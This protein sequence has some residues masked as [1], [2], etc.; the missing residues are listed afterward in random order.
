M[1]PQKRTDF[2]MATLAA[3][4]LATGACAS[5]QTVGGHAV[6]DFP[7]VGA[8]STVKLLSAGSGPKQM[9]RWMPKQGETGKLQVTL[10]MVTKTLA[11]GQ[12]FPDMS[13]PMTMVLAMTYRS[14]DGDR[15]VVDFRYESMK[16]SLPD[17]PGNVAETLAK[18]FEKIKGTMTLNT[19][20]VMQKYEMELPKGGLLAQPGM[21]RT[22][23]QMEDQMGKMSAPFPTEAV[24]VGAKWDVMQSVSIMGI[25][26]RSLTRFEL[27]SRNE[28]GGELAFYLEQMGEKGRIELPGMTAVK[29]F[30][31]KAQTKGKGGMSFRWDRPLLMGSDL[32]A[33]SG[34]ELVMEV[35]GETVDMTMSIDMN[36]GTKPKD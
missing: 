5:S 19:R 28:R 12:S 9:L 16:L 27:L 15:I 8:D 32:S 2:L 4:A 7:A 18:E 30:V 29:A 13:M 35:Q 21:K 24:G 17:V 14:V 31:K 6:T 34:M 3:L 11:S 10:D 25:T 33:K 36:M 1:M 22:M 20:G 23:E 26:Y